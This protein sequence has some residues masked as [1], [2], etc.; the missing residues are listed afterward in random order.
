[1]KVARE[2]AKFRVRVNPSACECPPFEIDLGG[3]WQRVEMVGLEA[4][5]PI[6]VRLDELVRARD[7][8]VIA[9]EGKLDEAL[10]L[11]ARGALYVSLVP[12]ALDA[13]SPGE[14]PPAGGTVEGGVGPDSSE[15]R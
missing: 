11:C 2:S 13:E 14:V 8:R 6:G 10:G 15:R 4:E 12:T 7:G 3:V 5:D 9:V 1:M